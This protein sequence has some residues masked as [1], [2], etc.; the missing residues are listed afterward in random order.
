[1]KGN[2]LRLGNYL[3]T[4]KG[5][6]VVVKL[7]EY[8]GVIVAPINE[9]DYDYYTLPI[10]LNEE[11]I[12]KLGFNECDYKPYDN[13]IIKCNNGYYNS[14]KYYEGEWVYNNDKSDASC[15][16]VT[17]IKYVHELQNLFYALNKTELVITKK[18]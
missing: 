16:T 15:Y 7:I 17:C 6:I 12:L 13:F 11:W 4:D 8:N 3:Q 1:M 14:I 10:P 9:E 2:E 5:D 18:G